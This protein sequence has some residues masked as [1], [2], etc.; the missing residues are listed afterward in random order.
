MNHRD[1]PPVT[2][3]KQGE[4]VNTSLFPCVSQLH[5]PSKGLSSCGI[6]LT[7]QEYRRIAL[8]KNKFVESIC[9]LELLGNETLGHFT[10][11]EDKYTPAEVLY[12]YNY[13]WAC[14][15]VDKLTAVWGD[16][17]DLRE[18]LDNIWNAPLLDELARRVYGDKR[19]L[20]WLDGNLFENS[21][22]VAENEFFREIIVLFSNAYDKNVFVP[23]ACPTCI[24][25]KDSLPHTKRNP[26]HNFLSWRRV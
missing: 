11:G 15:L 14:P 18:S 10:I 7:G 13:G 26:P 2:E 8:R 12:A 20:I 19:T 25:G 6:P 4:P 16:N 5:P 21:I 3:P 17:K 24:E 23:R 22:R 1:P 9:H